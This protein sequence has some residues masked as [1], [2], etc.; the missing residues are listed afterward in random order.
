MQKKSFVMSDMQKF[1]TRNL[2]SSFYTIKSIQHKNAW[3]YKDNNTF[4]KCFNF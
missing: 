2:I 1:A 4:S 3:K